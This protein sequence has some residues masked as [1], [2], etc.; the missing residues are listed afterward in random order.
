MGQKTYSSEYLD[1]FFAI[2]V[3]PLRCC[4]LPYPPP[5]RPLG[6]S[7]SPL[8]RFFALLFCVAPLVR[9]AVALKGQSKTEG[10]RNRRQDN[11]V[12]FALRCPRRGTTTKLLLQ[13]AK[14]KRSCPRRGLRSPFGSLCPGGGNKGLYPLRGYKR[15]LRP[16]GDS[17]FAL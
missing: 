10:Q 2:H 3:A 15:C 13:T 16:M 11:Y 17:C 1:C 8:V 12:V 9:F 7:S 6:F 5:V 4:L 14:R